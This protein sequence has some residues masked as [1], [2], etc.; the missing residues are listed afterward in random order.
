MSLAQVIEASVSDDSSAA[1]QKGISET[2]AI[3]ALREAR[4][5]EGYYMAMAELGDAYALRAL[6]VVRNECAGFDTCMMASANWMLQATAAINFVD[7]DMQD[8]RVRLMNAHASKVAED[9]QGVPGLLNARQV[10]DYHFDVLRSIG[11]PAATFGGAP[12]TGTLLE[13]DFWRQVYDWC[14]G[15]DTE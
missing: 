4:N 13:V 15:C 9:T 12:L 10:A 6:V 14:A 7:V 1:A 8:V 2:P 5:V 3:K 11:L